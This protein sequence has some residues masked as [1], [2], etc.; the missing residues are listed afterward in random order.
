MV[1]IIFDILNVGIVFL[2]V[3]K[4]FFMIVFILVFIL[5]V[6]IL[7]VLIWNLYKDILDVIKGIVLI[8]EMLDVI[9]IGSF[10]EGI[11]IGVLDEFD[12]MIVLK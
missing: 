2:M 11:K 9:L 3:F 10:Y 6:V 4:I 8:F 12:F 7:L 5:D 1:G